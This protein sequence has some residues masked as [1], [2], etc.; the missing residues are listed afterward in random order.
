MQAAD[1]DA[2]IQIVA[3]GAQNLERVFH[4]AKIK[5]KTLEDS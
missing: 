2:T 4:A 1:K 5:R 3:T